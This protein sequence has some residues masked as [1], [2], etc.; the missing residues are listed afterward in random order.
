MPAQ[1]FNAC[2]YTHMFA[3]VYSVRLNDCLFHGEGGLGLLFFIQEGPW[4]PFC[5]ILEAT[6]HTCTRHFPSVSQ[7][8]DES[9]TRRESELP[10]SFQRLRE[11]LTSPE[12]KGKNPGLFVKF[13][14][15]KGVSDAQLISQ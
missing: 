13:Q 10:F 11:C 14:Q 6:L 4:A 15:G 9:Q 1:C 12:M 5:E 2:L 7:D 8:K 3:C